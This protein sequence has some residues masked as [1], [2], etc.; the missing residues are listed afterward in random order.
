MGTKKLKVLL[1]KVGLDGHDVGVKVI[2]LALR[3]D[4]MEVI[5][6]GI[7]QT[8][9][10]VVQT[11][12]QEDVDV[13]GLNSLSG[14][15]EVLFPRVSELL[16]Q[17]DMDK[18]LLIGGGVIPDEDIPILKEQG[19]KEIFGPGTPLE[20]ITSFIRKNVQLE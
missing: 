19:F 12:V 13:V 9:E 8:P 10:A 14:G 11:A 20:D 5:Y 15:H 3:D 16:K 7:R 4:G 18:V 6:T 1:A 2:G 17:H